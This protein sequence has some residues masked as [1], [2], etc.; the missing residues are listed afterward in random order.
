MYSFHVLCDKIMLDG[1]IP[2]CS[3]W[4]FISKKSHLS[5]F[6]FKSI[7]NHWEDE[8]LYQEARRIV[9]AQI[10]HITYNEFLPLIVGKDRLRD[11]GINLQTYAY[12]SG[13]NLVRVSQPS[14]ELNV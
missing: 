11:Y 2:R 10:Q 5:R 4:R 3:C 1:S 6:C 9:I 14:Y 13:Y 8:R 12:D 7:N